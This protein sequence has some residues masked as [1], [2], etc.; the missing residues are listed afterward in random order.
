MHRDLLK[1]ALAGAVG[2]AIGAWAINQAGITYSKLT[3]F[4][5]EPHAG[6]PTGGGRE[7]HQGEPRSMA[8]RREPAT[9]TAAA[10]ISRNLFGHEPT[11]R[12]KNFGGSI[13]HYTFGATTGAAYGA[14]AEVAPLVTAGRGTVFGTGVWLVADELATSALGVADSPTKYPP[15][16]HLFAL[17]V[18]LAYGLA[19][20]TVRKILRG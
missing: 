13:L 15:R 18:H 5:E 2:G 20:E 7:R 4:A 1:G 9:K 3:G 14:L 12:E 17:V 8:D 10:V 6:P 19:T 16:T 11:Q